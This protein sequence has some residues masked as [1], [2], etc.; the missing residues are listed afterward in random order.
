M[1]C[2]QSSV[3]LP[4]LIRCE[5][6]VSLNVNKHSWLEGLLELYP[7]RLGKREGAYPSQY[8]LL[9]LLGY[10]DPPWLSWSSP[11]FA[12]YDDTPL[13]S[14]AWKS[15]IGYCLSQRINFFPFL[16]STFTRPT[17]CTTSVKVML[18]TPPAGVLD[19]VHSAAVPNRRQAAS[20]SIL[21]SH[22]IM[23]WDVFDR[24][25]L[26]LTLG[27]VLLIADIPLY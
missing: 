27:H 14:L 6:V 11:K 25:F 18:I 5:A 24:V 22:A 9:R 4:V 20:C 7:F 19:A 23:K 26:S 8:W 1:K 17:E 12:D 16:W 21:T 2:A 13:R 15:K 3:S 10:I